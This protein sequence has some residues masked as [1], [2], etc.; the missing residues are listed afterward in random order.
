M[1]FIDSN[2][3]NFG[4]FGILRRHGWFSQDWYM[5]V[6]VL[7][8][9]AALSSVSRDPPSFPG[10]SAAAATQLIRVEGTNTGGHRQ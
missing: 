8:G 2:Q 9:P 10:Q 7:C 6:F 3:E 5:L 4:W 1:F